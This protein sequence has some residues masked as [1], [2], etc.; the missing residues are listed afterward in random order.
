MFYSSK[1]IKN[2]N[3]YNILQGFNT[4]VTTEP[5]KREKYLA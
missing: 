2:N 1:F 4:E 5:R 3:K